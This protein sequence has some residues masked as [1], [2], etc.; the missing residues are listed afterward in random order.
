MNSNMK[1]MVVPTNKYRE[2]YDKIFKKELKR[3]CTN[4]KSFSNN[5]CNILKIEIE[6][7]YNNLNCEDWEGY[8]G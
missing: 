3:T 2:E 5:I 7:P 1:P 6:K 8:N 4:C